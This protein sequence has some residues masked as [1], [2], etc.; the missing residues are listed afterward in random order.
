MSFVKI[1]IRSPS[2]LLIVPDQRN[3]LAMKCLFILFEFVT[4]VATTF[5]TRVSK[6]SKKGQDNK[7]FLLSG[8]IDSSILNFDM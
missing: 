1:L 4:P 2:L 5:T 8:H 7:Y 3:D 6:Y